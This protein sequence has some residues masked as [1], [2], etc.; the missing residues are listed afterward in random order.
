MLCFERVAD[1]PKHGNTRVAL[2]P[3]HDNHENTKT[4]NRKHGPPGG[5]QNTKSRKHGPPDGDQNTKTRKHE[6]HE[7]TAWGYTRCQ[8]I[9]GD[10]E[11]LMDVRGALTHHNTSEPRV[12]DVQS[13]EVSQARRSRH[14]G[15]RRCLGA[16]RVI[17]DMAWAQLKGLP[18]METATLKA[19]ADARER[20]GTSGRPSP[21][22]V[23]TPRQIVW[24]RVRV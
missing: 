8:A 24:R 6:T 7:I 22:N 5:G 9:G 2:G 14:I 10:G 12:K 13:V 15:R 20:R 19:P 16:V 21:A 3:K 11:E 17:W 23:S 1:A 4:R 18:S